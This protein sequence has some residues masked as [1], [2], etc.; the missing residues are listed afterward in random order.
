MP[1]TSWFIYLDAHR[2]TQVMECAINQPS[3]RVTIRNSRKTNGTPVTIFQSRS[4]G[5]GY[6]FGFHVF[7]MPVNLNGREQIG[8]CQQM[9]RARCLGTLQNYDWLRIE[10]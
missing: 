5:D 6:R 1:W 3:T 2:A 10:E 9:R 7:E 4:T 8:W